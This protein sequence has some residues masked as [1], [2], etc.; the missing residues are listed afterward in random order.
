[1]DAGRSERLLYLRAIGLRAGLAVAYYRSS[2]FGVSLRSG[3]SDC[4]R[5]PLSHHLFLKS[6]V[7][8][9]FRIT[10]WMS[11]DSWRVFS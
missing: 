6:S 3:L 5:N 10:F 4:L 7:P 11:I 8:F 1:M 2:S 9:L